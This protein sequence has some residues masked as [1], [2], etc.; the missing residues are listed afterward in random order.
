MAHGTLF[1]SQG[2]WGSCPY[3]HDP[4]GV[5][6]TVASAYWRTGKRHKGKQQ[7]E[8]AGN[9]SSNYREKKKDAEVK[10]EETKAK[11]SWIKFSG[12]YSLREWVIL[13]IFSGLSAVNL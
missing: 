11:S 13:M 1:H 5:T 7:K 6:T 4:A 2:T 8:L 10:A 3:L 9:K 12:P